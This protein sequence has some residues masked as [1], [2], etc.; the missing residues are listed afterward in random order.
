L[1]AGNRF[2]AEALLDDGEI[3]IELQRALDETM[4]SN[5]NDDMARPSLTEAGMKS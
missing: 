3:L 4:S 1:P 2:D 5:G